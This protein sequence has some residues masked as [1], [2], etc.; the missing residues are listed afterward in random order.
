MYILVHHTEGDPGM[1]TKRYLGFSNITRFFLRV[2]FKTNMIPWNQI[3]VQVLGFRL[4]WDDPPDTFHPH[5]HFTR[6]SVYRSM[7]LLLDRHGLSGYQCVRRAICE[8]DMI[9][10]PNLIYHRI[11]KMIFRNQSSATEKWHNL[12]SETCNSAISSCPF[13][14]LDVSPY[15]DLLS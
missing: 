10:E 7:E 9:L 2:N 15:T 14:V 12:T 3:F 5:H 1:R 13:S 11:L 4:N 6:R 8:T